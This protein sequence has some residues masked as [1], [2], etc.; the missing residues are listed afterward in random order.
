MMR[1]LKS[2]AD[3]WLGGCRA[4]TVFFRIVA[5][6]GNLYTMMPARVLIMRGIICLDVFVV[7]LCS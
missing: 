4:I 6:I 5:I 1:S 2:S 7:S 3:S